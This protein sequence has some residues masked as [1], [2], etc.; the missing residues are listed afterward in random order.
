MSKADRIHRRKLNWKQKQKQLTPDPKRPMKKIRGPKTHRFA[1][2]LERGIHN[3]DT[4]ELLEM[5]R[6]PS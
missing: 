1:A 4:R 6:K 2:I 3:G 5:A